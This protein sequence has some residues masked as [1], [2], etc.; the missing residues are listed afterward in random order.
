MSTDRIQQLR[1]MK[2]VILQGGGEKK[3]KKQHES[4][5]MTARERLGLLFDEGSFV[6][7]D[8]FVKHRC[9]EFGMQEVDAP[10]EG[11]VSGYGTVEGRLVYAYAQ[12]FTV[13]GGSLGEMHANGS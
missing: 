6:E 2:E 8:A 10:G 7:I 11:V 12:D 4:G 3:I 13:V 1:K 5:K 9:T